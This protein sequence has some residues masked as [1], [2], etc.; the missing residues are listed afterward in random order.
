M[1]NISSAP[2]DLEVIRRSIR[3]VKKWVD[4][5]PVTDGYDYIGEPFATYETYTS[6][7][8]ERIRI[9]IIEQES[10]ERQKLQ[11]E[12]SELKIGKEK[13]ELQV[14]ELT[15]QLTAKTQELE[16]ERAKEKQGHVGW[17]APE[18]NEVLVE[19]LTPIFYS[20]REAVIEFLKDINGLK[21][22]EV[23]DKVIERVNLHIISDK[24]NR[25]P[26][27]KLLHAA[28]LYSATETNWNTYMKKRGA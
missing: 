20:D 8:I 15:E 22:E 24:S 14:Q 21:D 26:L 18:D 3:Y 10:A 4:E 2:C 7:D 12:N 13:L 5:N 17:T 23:A 19:L 6:A 28:K 11:Q 25:R 27:W 9:Q 1:E 16:M